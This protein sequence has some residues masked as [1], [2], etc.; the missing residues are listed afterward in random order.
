MGGTKP[1]S[2]NVALALPG[3][4]LSG[5]WEP[6]RA[7]RLAS[8]EL[9]VELS[10]RI[11]AIEIPDD[12]GSSREALDSLHA[13]FDTTRNIMRVH[14]PS[15]AR[16]SG[17]GNLCFGVIAVRILNDVLR[18]VTTEWHPRLEVYASQR[19][20]DVS[21]IEWERRWEHH[22][23]LRQAIRGVRP[24]VRQYLLVLAEAAEVSDLALAVLVPNGGLTSSDNGDG[25]DR[26]RALAPKLGF[27]P[28]HRMVRWFDLGVLVQT[29]LRI[30]R[31]RRRTTDP[32]EAMSAVAAP[33]LDASALAGT[34]AG[35]D[36]DFWF[37]YVADLGDAFDPTMAVAWQLGRDRVT[38]G[39]FGAGDHVDKVP[40]TGLPRGAFLVMGGDEVYPYP[41]PER[42]HAQ[43]TGPYGLALP[44]GRTSTVLAIPG[45]HDWYDG[46]DAFCETFL[47]GK[48]FGGWRTVQDA[49]WFSVRLPRGWWVWGLDTGLEGDIND[50]Q[51][52][53]F[54]RQA[55][56]LAAG[57]RIIVVH[58]IPAW[59]LREKRQ[60]NEVDHE[61]ARIRGL[62][63]DLLPEGVSAPLFL[64]G[65]SHVY[66]HYLER[67][68]PGAS[69]DAEPVHHVTSG[70]GG[71][72][73][74]PTHNLAPV[75][76][77]ST[78][79]AES[80]VLQQ[81]WPPKPVSRHVLNRS[82]AR[83][84]IDRQ[85][86]GLA[87][88][89]AALHLGVAAVAGGP[90]RSW[91]SA[92][93]GAGLATAIGS[94]AR[95]VLTAPG[96]IVALAVVVAVCAL[97]VPRPNVADLAVH[98][99]ARRAGALHGLVQGAA[100]LISTVVGGLV[101][102]ALAGDAAPTGP[103]LVAG[104]LV[105]ALLGGVTSVVVF[106]DYLRRV[107]GNYRIHDNEAFSGRHIRGYKHFVR[108]RIDAKGDLRAYVV[109]LETVRPGWGPA[110]ADGA[111]PPVTAPTLVDVVDVR[112]ARPAAPT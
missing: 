105:G 7:E 110:L 72:F 52:A 37:D 1:S 83:L 27:R 79:E 16:S 55:E 100:F 95:E 59:R 4:S 32:R 87:L 63:A 26:S 45:N 42:Y 73:L 49:S 86:V 18:P 40:A 92:H 76:P 98:R 56:A 2:V 13:V 60:D 15:L 90:M 30:F 67:P 48:R 93:P 38:P 57:D 94:I 108:L 3:V 35:P 85:N 61:M 97:V 109:G 111:A 68:L 91:L 36:G 10:T 71:A 54:T 58:P 89:L 8:W 51:R 103:E 69:D 17:N 19:P 20:A 104:T 29:G 11:T 102:L 24:I 112:A 41:S 43:T 107:N 64:A 82:T 46:L 14:G 74:H 78:T 34:E 88:L 106:A 39:E 9:L 66:T 53:Y 75:V 99:V 65:D 12:E 50:A 6:D 21:E 84:V 23:E 81:H 101:A 44:P 28:R 33:M 96:S 70:G 80:Y 77:Q 62:L 31:L 47:T 22:A 5:T 25:R